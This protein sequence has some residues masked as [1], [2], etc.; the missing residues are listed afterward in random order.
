MISIKI[1][2]ASAQYVHTAIFIY[3]NANSACVGVGGDER[4][5]MSTTLFNVF[6]LLHI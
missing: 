5:V 1:K 3:I 6:Y 4:D 2:G